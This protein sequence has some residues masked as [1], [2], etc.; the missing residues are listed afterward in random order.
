MTLLAIDG[1]A[2]TPSRLI[3]NQS[4]SFFS[5]FR[6]AEQPVTLFTPFKENAIK[7]KKMFRD[8]QRDARLSVTSC[9]SVGRFWQGCAQFLELWRISNTIE[10]RIVQIRLR[11]GRL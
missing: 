3:E 7:S 5:N 4:A 2:H 6:A 9:P 11:G 8:G 10:I 1:D